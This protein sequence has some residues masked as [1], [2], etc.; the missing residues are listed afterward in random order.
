MVFNINVPDTVEVVQDRIAA[1][2]KKGKITVGLASGCFDLVHFYHFSF[3][4]RCRQNCDILIV[5]VDSDELVRQIKGPTRPIVP[6]FH[7]VIMVDALRPVTFAFVMNG[8]DD[9]GK[10]AKIFKPDVIFKNDAFMGKEAD[11]VGKKHAKKVMILHD[12]IDHSSTS[13][14]I[15]SLAGRAQ[16]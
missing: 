6:D 1:L 9:F 7:R 14:I 5:G 10:A 13:A 11:I 8:L 3:F 16:K 4:I 2:R 15:A 12:Q